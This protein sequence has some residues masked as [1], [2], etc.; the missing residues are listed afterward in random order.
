MANRQYLTHPTNFISRYTQEVY[1]PDA[2][3]IASLH[4]LLDLI[5]DDNHALSIDLHIAELMK[6]E[7][8][9]QPLHYRETFDPI[10]E[11]PKP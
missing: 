11:Q 9:G 10:L 6:L 7:G 4:R 1:T 3:L 2:N 8:Y 5:K